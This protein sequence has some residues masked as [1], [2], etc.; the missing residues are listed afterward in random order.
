M[1]SLKLPNLPSEA[2]VPDA[3]GRVKRGRVGVT[4]KGLCQGEGEVVV[5]NRTAS[6]G[7]FDRMTEQYEMMQR[8]RFIADFKARSARKSWRGTC[9]CPPVRT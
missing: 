3:A 6:Q 5:E 8:R 2:I 1:P 9:D 7:V 4:S